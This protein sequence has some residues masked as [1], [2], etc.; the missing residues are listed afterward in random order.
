MV[1]WPNN[2]QTIF[3][4][5]FSLLASRHRSK[6]SCQ[7]KITNGFTK[8]FEIFGAIFQNS[9]VV[10]SV[11]NVRIFHFFKDIHLKISKLDSRLLIK[12][13]TWNSWLLEITALFWSDYKLWFCGNALIVHNNMWN[14]KTIKSDGPWP[15]HSIITGKTC[16]VVKTDS[17]PQNRRP[18]WVFP[19]VDAPNNEFGSRQSYWP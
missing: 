13:L 16:C 17:I 3:L 19:D 2:D 14:R 9:T 4:R 18:W 5:Q 1:K 10:N 15:I 12:L 8:N 7:C 11:Q 6:H